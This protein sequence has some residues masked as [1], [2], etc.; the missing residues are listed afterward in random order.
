MAKV[1]KINRVLVLEKFNDKIV[2]EIEKKYRPLSLTQALA[3]GVD[4][5]DGKLNYRNVDIAALEVRSFDAFLERFAPDIYQAFQVDENGGYFVY[6]T[7]P[8]EYP[9]AIQMKFDRTS[10]FKSA[11]DMYEKK[12]VSGKSNYE[13]DYSCFS[14]LIS[15]ETALKEVKSK[16]SQLNYSTQ[17]MLEAKEANNSALEKKYKKQAI[18]IVD[19]VNETYKDNPT[20]LLCLNVADLQV[21]LGISGSDKGGNNAPALETSKGVTYRLTYNSDGDIVKENVSVTNLNNNMVDAAHRLETKA[22]EATL[23]LLESK[24]MDENASEG[25]KFTQN[26]VVSTYSGNTGIV[27]PEDIPKFKKKYEIQKSFYKASQDSLLKSINK[28]IEK[29]LD[30]KALFDNAGS[31]ITVIVSN[32]TAEDIT[33]DS[34]TLE[35]FT[36]YMK[37][38]NSNIENKIWFA[39]LPQI[40]DDDLV[41]RNAAGKL[42]TPDIPDA[43]SDISDTEQDDTEK[44]DDII[45]ASYETVDEDGS[46]NRV[47]AAPKEESQNDEFDDMWSEDDEPTEKQSLISL[48]SANQIIQILTDAKCTTFFGF[49]ACEK[50]GFN[51]MNKARLEQYK[52]KLN[53]INSRYAVFAY[54]N[55][56]LMSGIQA[57]N[58]EIA[59]RDFIEN[60]GMYLDA[61]YIAAGIVVKS[62]N[63][64]E[65]EKLKFK[66]HKDLPSPCVRFDFEDSGNE[67]ENRYKLKTN[68]N[69][70]EIKK[71]DVDLLEELDRSPF[72]FFFDSVGYFNGERVKNTFAKYARNMGK[73]ENRIFATLV[74]DFIW[75]EMANGELKI[76]EKTIEDYK[77]KNKWNRE[78]YN[79]CVNNPLRH[80]E[81]YKVEIVDGKPGLGIHFNNG[82]A[83]DMFDEIEIVNTEE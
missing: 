5:D 60:P 20:A 57:G 52:K 73:G 38:I 83:M 34:K 46:V 35:H 25:D 56:T 26:L 12:A 63:C 16:R 78:T 11:I 17:K 76:S 43:G 62:L 65:L 47:E 79:G 48:Q 71:Y 13:F 19:D 1:E 7:D 21:K 33:N 64:R 67:Y 15:P 37:N 69:C 50:T 2:Y 59:P 8:E 29:M 54:P 27:S 74:K 41:D 45:D 32:C 4:M 53:G 9:G 70:E 39:V 23:K 18:A 10:F 68:M 14:K 55:F 72:G 49:K 80:G 22:A 36:T 66:T 24:I 61:P 58:I 82:Q 77:T 42:Y 81:E 6:S 3:D 51:K 31:D 44:K 30:V 40:D 28:I 75:L